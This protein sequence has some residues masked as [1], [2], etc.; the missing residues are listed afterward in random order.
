M[1]DFYSG[2]KKAVFKLLLLPQWKKKKINE[3][4]MN[5]RFL[6]ELQLLP[7]KSYGY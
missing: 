6:S 7:L 5:K 3:S 1:I 2:K 4:E